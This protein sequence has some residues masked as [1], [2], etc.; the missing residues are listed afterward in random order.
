MTDQKAVR[1]EKD[2]DGV[3][4]VTLDDPNASANTMNDAYKQA[5]G[6]VITELEAAKDDIT[7]VVITS[8]KKTFFAGGNLDDLISAKPDDGPAVFEN[9]T[10]VKAQLRRLEKLA[11]PVVAAMNGTALGGGLEIGLACHH[12]IGLDAKGVVYGLPEVTLGLLPGGGGVTRITRL[13]GIAGGFMNVLAQGQ[14]LTPEKALELGVIHELAASKE[15]AITKAKA[16]IAAN[17]EA[18]QPWDTPGYKIPGG[19]PSNPK[20]AAILPAFPANLRKQLKGAP[21]PAPRNILSAAVE[22][23]QVDF[24]TALRIESR[25]FVDLV[26]GQT[27]KNMIKAFFFDLNAI[28]GGKSRPDGV[29]KYTPRKVAVLGA[30]M[31]GAGI[32]YVCAQAGWEVV[33]KDVSLEAAEKGKGYSEGLVAKGVKRGKVTLEKG[34]AL[35]QRITPTA[36]YNDLAGCDIVIEAVF[37]SV[38]LKQE[39]FREAMKVVEPDALLCSNTSTLPIT[40]LAAGID[41]PGDFIGLHFFSPVDKM[42]L[43]EII[44]GER[45]SDT[46]LAKAFDVTLGIRKT[47]I[48]VNDSRGFFTSRVIG[49]FVNEGISM[50]AEGIDP[51]TIEQAS[52]QAGYPAPVLQ[53]MDELTL[54]LPQKIRKETQAAAGDSWV[55]H[56]ADEIV[57]R[58]VDEFGRKGKSSGAGFYEY[59]EGRRVRLW[60]GLREQF[61]A[62][63]HE[64]DLQELS[65]RMLVIESL[66][67]VRCF[68]EGVLE[69]V[70]DANIG[71]IFGIGFPAWTGGVMQYIEGYPGGVVGFVKRADEFAAKYGPRFEVPESLRKRAQEAAAA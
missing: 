44:K 6:E 35:L 66:E 11:R 13:L 65:E 28:N 17:P 10:E 41:R 67:T 8:A 64:V 55:P 9:V 1:W 54:T 68:D 37:E 57:D 51:Q 69:T 31:M 40:E 22:G 71:S 38:E 3:A 50:L 47:P 18:R 36:D 14:R 20:L 19:T 42:P 12:R 49:T 27:S 32:A 48:V 23:A 21:M 46:T 5:M 63:N 60:P 25:Y 24:D 62:T 58:M 30:G 53:L 39:V 34:E 29:E 26:V 43:V 52:A 7:G 56:P 70:P 59:A 33:L 15:E 2:S 45:T 61:G 16:W 4:I